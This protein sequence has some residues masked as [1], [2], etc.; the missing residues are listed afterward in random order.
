M[1]ICVNANEHYIGRG[2][3]LEVAFGCPDALPGEIDYGFAGACNTK[4]IKLGAETVDGTT[5]RTT[6]GVKATFV[7]YMNFEVTL[8]GK[9]RKADKADE[10]NTELFKY[11]AEEIRNARQPSVWVRVTYPDITV[12]AY[13]VITDMSRSA[14]D[15]DM[16]TFNIT[17]TATESDFGVVITDTV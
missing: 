1:A 16:T 4:D 7:T 11:Y 6:G 5:D 3:V 14:P 10:K 17:L 8:D 13:C 9:C 15:S 12:V 2:V